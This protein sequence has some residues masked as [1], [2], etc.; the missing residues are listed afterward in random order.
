MT[1]EAAAYLSNALSDDTE[2]ALPASSPLILA[3][4]ANEV[5][6]ATTAFK[7][8]A[9][10]IS[11]EDLIFQVS[12]G[13]KEALTVLFRRHAKSVFNV[14]HRILRDK[15]EAEDV[16][17]DLFLFV[18]QKA[19]LFD[20]ERGPGA[21]WIIQL[22]YHRAIDRRRYLNARHHYKAKEFDDERQHATYGQVSI[23][24]LTGRVL[25]DKLRDELSVEQQQTL[26]LHFFEGYTFHEIAER[27]GQAFGNVRHQYYRGLERLRSF[28]FP[29]K[30]V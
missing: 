16:L 4:L 14:A 7:A 15:S 10:E 2:V 13:R 8:L 24:Q 22:A 30:N 12:K 6:S 26:E 23:D 29:D 20:A 28:V 18:F 9:Q 5:F 27:T 3:P 21:S 25:L 17:Q 1:F 11:D 19:Q